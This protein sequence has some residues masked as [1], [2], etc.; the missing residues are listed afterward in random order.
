MVDI[1]EN[2]RKKFD[3]IAERTVELLTGLSGYELREVKARVPNSRKIV[4]VRIARRL[5]R[6]GPTCDR[7]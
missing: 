3:W 6:S 1:L 2:L 5:P 7:Y 4:D